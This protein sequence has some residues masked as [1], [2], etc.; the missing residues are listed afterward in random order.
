MS[1]DIALERSS[2]GYEVVDK[3]IGRYVRVFLNTGVV[4]TGVL[5]ERQGRYILVQNK[6]AEVPALVNLDGVSSIT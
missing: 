5:V 6:N 2:F 4:L 1:N 3:Y